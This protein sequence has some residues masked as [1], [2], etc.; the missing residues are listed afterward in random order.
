MAT[1]N[2]TQELE[3]SAAPNLG[4]LLQSRAPGVIIAPNSGRVGSGP[5]VWIRGRSSLSLSNEPIVYIDGVRVNNAVNQG[6]PSAGALGAQ[7]RRS[8]HG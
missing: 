6:P 2:A 7:N 8:R 5:T 4:T 1:I 3:R